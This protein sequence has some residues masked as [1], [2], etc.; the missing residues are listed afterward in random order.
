METF[1][2]P[3]VGLTSLGLSLIERSLL[4]Y[5]YLELVS[6]RGLRQSFEKLRKEYGIIQA[7]LLLFVFPDA[8]DVVERIEKHVLGAATEE[9]LALKRSLSSDCSML[10]VAV[11]RAAG[12]IYFSKL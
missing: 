4:A 1:V 9:A 5:E 8:R 2:I 3:L 10:A 11:S 6:L 7:L 12:V